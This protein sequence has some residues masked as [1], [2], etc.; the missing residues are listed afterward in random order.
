MSG[1]SLAVVSLLT[2][3]SFEATNS[4]PQAAQNLT[5]S[6]ASARRL[7]AL[8]E[9]SSATANGEILP[10]LS[11][12]QIQSV[13][14]L[15]VADLSFAYSADGERVLEKIN[16]NLQRGKITALVGPS[17][18]GK[19][20]LVNL[21]LRFWEPSAG[22]ILVDQ[23]NMEEY[24]AESTRR[25]FGVISQSNYFFAETLRNNLLYARPD[26]TD[27]D[28]VDVLRTAELGAWYS[29]LSEGLDTWLGEQGARM[30]GGEA[31]RLAVARVLLQAAPFILLDEPTANLDPDTER[32]LL[33]TLFGLFCDKG[34]L[35][36]THRLVMLDQA[37]KILF[38]SGG[39][40][41]ESG[42]E[43]NLLARG[44]AYSRFWKMQ[45]NEIEADL[46]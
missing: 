45:R 13:R 9:H 21:L 41:I 31:Q 10:A 42:T 39:K 34:V 33:T 38:L 1:V 19:T 29:S 25:L 20:S 17:G 46:A 4:L 26:A 36:I 37:D 44:G 16:L 2:M 40:V 7:F 43:T 18:A 5:A 12:E 3:A 11:T 27:S 22:K 30:S 23:Q 14:K 15:T 32:K 28:L 24:S 35:L 6:I 8:V